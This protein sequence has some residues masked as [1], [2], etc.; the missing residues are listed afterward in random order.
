VLVESA[1]RWRRDDHGIVTLTIDDPSQRVN[2]LNDL[3]ARSFAAVVDR[4]E[5]ELADVT[6]VIV[7]SAKSSFLAGGDLKRLFAIEPSG[8]QQFLDDLTVRKARMRRFETLGRPVVAILA[9]A[10]LGGGLELA[11]VCHHRIAV[12]NE[13]VS[14]G[15]PEAT[16]GLLPGGGGLTRTTRMLGPRRALELIVSGT[17]LSASEGRAAG[18]LDDVAETEDDA[19]VRARA[20][21][22]EHPDVQQPWD[23]V[24]GPSPA[25]GF[26]LSSPGS[27]APAGKKINELVTAS[28]T[29]SFDDALL[30]ESEALADLVVSPSAKATMQ[31][32]FFDTVRIR[33]R[34]HAKRGTHSRTPVLVF[35]DPVSRRTLGGR[36][37]GSNVAVVDL[38][39][40]AQVAEL[41]SSAAHVVFEIVGPEDS[42]TGSTSQAW[43]HE[44]Q[45][46]DG[47]LVLEYQDAGADLDDV[48][49]VLS[50]L[51]VLPIA[52]QPGRGSFAA[53][54]RASGGGPAGA[55]EVLRHDEDF[56]VA[57]VRLG[58]FPAWT[59][60][61]DRWS[62]RSENRQEPLPG[63]VV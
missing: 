6:G 11:L 3:F 16:L 17:R 35:D 50:R 7:T 18:L 60:G 52:L 63:K 12:D 51:S 39:A 58:G 20:W 41:R 32:V 42:G 2:T 40:E 21:I 15:L 57:S 27:D 45:L 14:I 25:D 55:R 34:H 46:G 8:R 38:S 33:S 28:L 53:G 30:A 5:A 10:A 61:A 23:R 1:I 59:G 24:D 13:R 43:L 47:G 56:D 44:D 4:L 19:L 26:V 9:G 49:S 36:E 22:L 29:M 62:N 54:F 37:F 31:V 48:L